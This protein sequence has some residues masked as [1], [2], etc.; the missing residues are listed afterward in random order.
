MA[1]LL[2]TEWKWDWRK[3]SDVA[4]CGIYAEVQQ[5]Q[6]YAIARCPR[7]LTEEQWTEIATRI[8]DL[9]NADLANQ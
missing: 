9:H 4:N 2:E 8:C 5:G 3:D 7:Y 6:A 1:G